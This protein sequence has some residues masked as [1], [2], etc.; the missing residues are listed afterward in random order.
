MVYLYFSG[1][2]LQKWLTFVV[3]LWYLN[4]HFIILSMLPLL[5]LLVKMWAL[6]NECRASRKCTKQIQ[7]IQL[8]TRIWIE[9]K[10]QWKSLYQFSKWSYPISE[11]YSFNMMSV[12]LPAN[13]M[14]FNKNAIF[15]FCHSL[16]LHGIRYTWCNKNKMHQ[17]VWPVCVEKSKEK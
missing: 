4:L 11:T 14:A 3:Y 15:R 12:L 2:H 6:E 7:V 10:S 5:F 1:C 9:K 13:Q 8:F 17:N 16:L